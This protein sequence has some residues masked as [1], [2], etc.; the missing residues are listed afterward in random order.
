MRRLSDYIAE[1]D[2]VEL[3][4]IAADVTGDNVHWVGYNDE[5]GDVYEVWEANDEG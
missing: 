2:G 4:H 3:A 1:F 5:D